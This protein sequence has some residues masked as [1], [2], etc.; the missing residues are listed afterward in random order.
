MEEQAGEERLRRDAV[1]FPCGALTLKGV[2][3]SPDGD[4]VFP[5]IVL[6]HPHP[7]YGGSMDNN[8]I[9]AVASALVGSSVIALMF[10][11]RGVGGS[12]GGFG[13]GITE[14]EDVV[15][16]I[17]WLACQ[18]E[19]DAGRLGLLGYSFGASVAL[20]VACDDERIQ[21]MA[22]V[23]PPLEPPQISRLKDCAKPK[24]IMC[25][26]DDFVVPRHRAELIGQEAAEPKQFELISGVD[27]F[28][29]GH[30]V[31]VA[32][33]VAAFFGGVFRTVGA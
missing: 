19:V 5:A 6:C 22:L 15:A 23:S 33:Q 2:C 27:H 14:Q 29:W 25:G 13:G 9:V 12:E 20:P 24:L 28:W 3:C 17:S 11:F 26:A 1:S 21:A 32:R 30:E 4:G 31:A 16:A 18:P 10:N 8:V 7:L